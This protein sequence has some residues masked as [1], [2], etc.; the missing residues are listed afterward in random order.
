MYI[1]FCEIFETLALFSPIKY[2]AKLR[3]IGYNLK[4]WQNLNYIS[5]NRIK[6]IKNLKQ[7]I[8][9]GEKLNVAFFIYDDTKWKCQSI[10]DLMESSKYFVPHI[11]VTKN[12]SPKSN[13]N[14]QLKE[15]LPK[16]YDFFTK[17]GLRVKYA[18]DFEKD[19]YI[20]FEDMDPKPDIVYYCHPWYVYKT[21]GPVMVSKYALTYYS[22]Y[23]VPTSMGYQEYS[24]RFHKYIG[25]QYVINDVIKE[26]FSENMENKGCNI[27]VV[28]HPI[29][30]FFYL[31]KNKNFENKNSIIYAPHF[32]IDDS[33]I[34]KW[35]TFLYFGEFILEYAKKHPEF[36]WIFK[37]HP[38]LRS[39]LSLKKYWDEDKIQNYW[40]EWNKIGSVYE[41]GDYLEMFMESKAM[42]T[43]C[44]SFKTE[45]FMTQ[46]PQIYLKSKNPVAYNPNVEKINETCY[47]A[48]TKEELQKI[49]EQVIELSNDYKKQDRE[50]IYKNYGYANNYCAKNI[51]NDIEKTV[52][53]NG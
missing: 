41:S 12:C 11:F 37:P 51:M 6:V 10:Y 15:T 32:S 8:K 19:D 31:N 39:Y 7:K 40:N 3:K 43:D 2:R 24:L 22:S 14:Y 13:F 42:I 33:T 18:Y 20:A 50:F 21:Q 5:K 35:G 46:K 1:K 48:E 17:K 27:K 49:F 25:T 36:N 53:I 45:Y 16:I 23:S 44:G 28:G 29:L 52:G 26:Y 4:V 47:K 9:N 38:C 30:D 34:L